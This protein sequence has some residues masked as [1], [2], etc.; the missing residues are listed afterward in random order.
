LGWGVQSFT[1]AAMAALGE[2]DRIDYAVHA[3]T[4]HESA[5][6]YQFAERWTGW[7]DIRGIKVVTVD[8]G[9]NEIITNRVGGEIFIPSF[10]NT[11]SSNGGQLRRQCTQRW[12][13]APLRRWLQTNRNGAPVEMWIGISTDEALRMKPSDVKYITH[14]WPLIE[15]GMSR[16]DCIKFLE[17]HRLET[18][19][20]SAC[21]F[22]PYHN[23]YEWR[24]TKEIKKD[25]DKAVA[26]DER[27]RNVRP[28]YDLF[29][30]PSRKPLVS[31]DLRTEEQKGQMRLWDEECTGL[32]GV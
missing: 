5:M 14:R 20:K 24:K 28:P 9:E 23:T 26:I 13:I 29:V 25:W 16:K 18:P 2:I 11:P 3:D 1:L 19:S 6:T 32:C 21:V 12:K 15:L 4:H 17:T 7:L 8:N 27:I 31:V 10:T 22:C 30:H